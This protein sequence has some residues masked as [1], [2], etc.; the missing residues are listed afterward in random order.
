MADLQNGYLGKGFS[1]ATHYFNGKLGMD[2]QPMDVLRAVNEVVRHANSSNGGARGEGR[3][4]IMQ[5][6]V[7]G[8]LK[9]IGS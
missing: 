2:V 7:C 3:A 5:G 4:C 6:R 8:S 9:I 1:R